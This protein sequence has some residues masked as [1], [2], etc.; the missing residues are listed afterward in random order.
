MHPLPIAAVF[1]CLAAFASGA[2][3]ADDGLDLSLPQASTQ[4][5]DP[6]GTFYG[7]TSGVP[8]TAALADTT[9]RLI[10]PACPTTPDGRAT[11]LTGS[12]SAG[13]G[14]SSQLGNSNYQA[15]TLNWCKAYDGDDG[16]RGMV[17]V[18][19]NVG[20][21]EGP[22]VRPLEPRPGPGPWPGPWPAR[23][24]GGVGR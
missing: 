23:S 20:N 18:Q 5:N 9:A 2:Y 12:V 8:A 13:V 10:R 11:D 4:R 7:D 19:L 24:D 16:D 15:A 17:N 6:P 14:Y 1:A 21:Y 22:D 3:A